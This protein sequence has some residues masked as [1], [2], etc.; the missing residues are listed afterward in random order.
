MAR[1]GRPLKYTDA[2]VIWDLAQKY[3]KD[4]DEKGDPYLITGV[5]LALDTSRS[6]L[7]EWENKRDDLSDTIKRIK[8]ICEDWAAKNL[9]KSNSGQ[10]G[11]IFNLKVNHGW[12]DKQIIQQEITGE[13]SLIDILA[14]KDKTKNEDEEENDGA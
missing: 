12:E 8:D 14:K 3:F 5:A 6:T 13:L 7:I 10:I 9:A 11:K 4:C 2:N 1:T